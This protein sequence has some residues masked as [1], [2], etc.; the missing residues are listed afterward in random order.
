MLFY[1]FRWIYEG[2]LSCPKPEASIV[3]E[4]DMWF[5]F[6]LI[7]LKL[8]ICAAATL[9]YTMLGRILEVFYSKVKSVLKGRFFVTNSLSHLFE[10]W[11]IVFAAQWSYKISMCLNYF[12]FSL[13]EG[14]RKIIGRCGSLMVSA[15]DSGASAPGPSPLCSWAI[16]FTLTV[17]LSTQGINGYRRI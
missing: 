8:Q 1:F 9:Y 17:P 14:K 3:L 4:M 11:N 16:H 2:N 10:N 12:P 5:G 15:L 7:K 13:L 6:I